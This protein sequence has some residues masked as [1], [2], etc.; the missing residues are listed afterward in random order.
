MGTSRALA[1]KNC[2]ATR[3]T[4]I[5]KQWL[6]QFEYKLDDQKRYRRGSDVL[7]TN[8][9]AEAYSMAIAERSHMLQL[10]LF[11]NSKYFQE[12]NHMNSLLV[13]AAPLTFTISLEIFSGSYTSANNRW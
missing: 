8:L 12:V 4:I 5:S 2:I 7:C 1:V 13:A 10:H 9:S 3:A 6:A 11:T